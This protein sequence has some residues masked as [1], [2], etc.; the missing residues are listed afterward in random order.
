VNAENFARWLQHQGYRVV[1]TPSS[2]WYEASRGVFQAFPYQWIIEPPEREL[3]DL[4]WRERAFALRYST[5][6]SAPHGMISYHVVC[7]DPSYDIATLSRQS[8]QNV[9][10]GL[11]H[12]DVERISIDRLATDGWR[13]R[14]ETLA[15]QGRDGAESEAWWRRLCESAA[16]LD[17]F[18]AWGALHDG[19]LMASFLAFRSD[20]CYSLPYEQSASSALEYRVN[21]AIFYAV[22]HEAIQQEDISQVFLCLHSLDAPSSVDEFKFRM[23]CTARPVRQRVVF[24]PWLAPALNRPSHAM[25][26]KLLDWRSGSPVLPKIEGM[27]R[28]YLEGRRGLEEQAWP[29]CLVD[30]REEILR[31]A[32]GQVGE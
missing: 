25:L 11:K 32:S 6:V 19:E 27:V 14:Q 13:L 28:F 15:R 3:R 31:S 21:N 24:H 12:V 16:G 1:R 30:R 18:E 4:L 8:R 22:I 2:Y 26:R 20:G 7:E 17:G 9:R 29:E 23:G 5:S 10:K